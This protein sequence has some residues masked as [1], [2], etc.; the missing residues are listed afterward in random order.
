M[1]S[2]LITETILGALTGYITNDTAIRSLFKPNGIIEKTRDDFA[3]EAGRLL[4]SQVLTPTVLE[5]QLKLPEVQ[6][7]LVRLLQ[8]FLHETLPES[9]T[10][11]TFGDLPEQEITVQY[12]QELLHRFVVSEK[13]TVLQLLKKNLPIEHLLTVEQCNLLTN[14]FELLFLDVMKQGDFANKLWTSWQKEKGSFTL[15]DFG[16]A[17]FCHTIIQNLAHD[18]V[19]WLN[20]LKCDYSEQLKVAAEQSVRQLQLGPVLMELDLQMER[21]TIRQYLNCDAEE[22][23]KALHRLLRSEHGSRLLDVIITELLY[24][25]E[26][27]EVSIHE[28][29]PSAM[30][31]DMVPL[32]QEELPMVLEGILDWVW[33][34]KQSVQHMLEESIDEIAV[35]TGGMK[36]MLLQHVKDAL[37]HEIMESADTYRSILDLI[38]TDT[39]TDQTVDWIMQKITA[40]L[41]DHTIGALVK[42]LN[43]NKALHTMLYRFVMENVDRYLLQADGLAFERLLNWSPG[44]LQLVNHQKEVEDL[45]VQLLLFAVEEIDSST[46]I[47]NNRVTITK[48][49]LQ[50]LLPID[51]NTF[52]QI[53]QTSIHKLCGFSAENLSKQ[54]SK[55]VYGVL[56]DAMIW[57]LEQYGT[58]KLD[59]LS[60]ER[61]VSDV[62][63]NVA[64]IVDPHTEQIAN[65]ASDIALS[66]MQG[67]LSYLAEAQI[68][69]LS[70]AEMLELVE[71]FMGRELQPLN[72]LGAGM[73]AMAGASV[74]FALSNAIPVASI[75][76]PMVTAGVLAGKTAIF[77]AVGY[78]TNCAAVKGL[79]WPYEPI[80]GIHT[81]QGVIPKQKERFAGSMGRLVD[82]YVINEEILH[83]QINSI[84]QQIHEQHV[85]KKIAY[86]EALYQKLF[87]VLATERSGFSEFICNKITEYSL[88]N[89]ERFWADLGDAS[90][91]QVLNAISLAD[92]ATLQKLY[93][94]CLRLL[95]SWLTELLHKDIPLDTMI[96]A[97]VLWNWLEQQLSQISL[98]DFVA[99][100]QGVLSREET[101]QQ[102]MGNWYEPT[103]K[104]LEQSIGSALN[105]PQTQEQL[106]ETIGNLFDGEMVYHWLVHNSNAWVKD[107]LTMLFHIIETF[108]LEFMQSRQE[109]LT[110]II[111]QE[112]RS[113]M[114]FM[115][116]MGYAMMNGKEIVAAVVDRLL[117]QKLPIFLR[118]KR[119]EL[120]QMLYGIWEHRLSAVVLQL[121]NKHLIDHTIIQHPIVQQCSVQ[122][123]KD[124]LEFIG[125]L[126]M[127]YWGNYI[128][129]QEVLAKPQM[130]LGFQWQTHC[131]DIL[132]CWKTTL[133]G[134]MEQQLH[135]LTLAKLTKGYHEQIALYELIY[136]TELNQTILALLRNLKDAS[137]STRLRDWLDWNAF[138]MVINQ[139]TNKLLSQEQVQRWMRYETN[140][141]LLALAETPEQ[142]LPKESRVVLIERGMQA[143]FFVAGKYGTRLLEQ[144][145]LSILAEEQLKQMDS[146]ELEQ[147]V[148]GF[149]GHY[150]VHI[151][152]RG[153]LGAIFALPGMLVYLF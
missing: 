20:Q 59:Q 42:K 30:L 92:E 37:L 38:T 151:Q 50:Q 134:F 60:D 145:Q 36:G 35:E 89:G 150:L 101:L 47:L 147:V 144:M 56:Y 153:W 148:R 65:F 93:D 118:V 88:E 6:A 57:W 97:D 98:P 106:T 45:L 104:K 133:Q 44:S 54:S 16:L 119:R 80:A 94:S 138:S 43:Q 8:E 149:A 11:V 103:I 125:T 81:I 115:M 141:A 143:V 82:R 12:I 111:E 51:A 14:Q 113:H 15:A 107:N 32:L 90:L 128:N 2:Q 110:V 29:L 75:T 86:D 122:L 1:I 77:G 121:A 52:A 41:T 28:A 132:H 124:L 31:E 135:E 85:I 78:T 34:N 17:P 105:R 117:H 109:K 129:I 102:V 142:L 33:I 67:R 146:A 96:N 120:E 79:F 63:K 3:R 62:I 91:S 64:D 55:D 18:S 7:E 26:R 87:A 4:E 130:Q 48:T 72:Y 53:L 40:E 13:E 70:S 25:L 139:G 126:P 24:A 76:N 137:A 9:F 73:G 99:I 21:Y 95:S 66:M 131:V 71:D 140:L 152:N 136:G 69:S 5:H 46:L 127:H 27:V 10:D 23:A 114:G 68:Q 108:I 58:A 83:E 61:F 123:C 112:V 100:V 39:T 84:Y 116:Q 22:L 19:R 49:P 74:G